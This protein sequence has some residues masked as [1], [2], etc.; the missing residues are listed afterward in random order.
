M[1]QFCAQYSRDV[2]EPLAGTGVHP[3][4]NLLL[5]WP[6]GGW[7]RTFHQAKDM[8]EGVS[9]R[10]FDLVENG[11]R[12][13]LMHRADQPKGWH[14]AYLMPERQAY[15]IPH[16]DVELF[17]TALLQGEPLDAWSRGE[18]KHRVLLC[19][20]HGVKDKCCAKFGNA[21]F[22]AMENAARE[23]EGAF[24]I[25][26]STHLGGCRLASAALLFPA[27]H[28]YG[29]IDPEHARPL[30]QSEIENRPYL[31]CY[32]GDGAL[33]PAQQIADIEA[34][35][36]LNAREIFPERVEVVAEQRDTDQTSCIELQWYRESDQGRITIHL[37][38]LEVTR[39]GTCADI[40]NDEQP[41][42]HPTWKPVAANVVQ[43][44]DPSRPRGL[45]T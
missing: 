32:R 5:S 18:V 38:A 36:R 27:M 31:P 11:R 7:T 20:T 8:T 16:D 23:W 14:R 4:S 6:I 24:E 30:L 37:E 22:K 42:T 39:Y 35:K 34:R 44:F 45:M 28:K 3:V 17:L 9:R 1:P 25:W 43:A 15:D 29:R 10:V 2:K 26:K 13:N 41:V 12:I 19:C 33:T 40:D 21:T